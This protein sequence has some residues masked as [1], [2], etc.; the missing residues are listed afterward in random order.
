MRGVPSL[1]IVD[2]SGSLR[3][4]A[5][6]AAAASLSSEASDGGTGLDKFLRPPRGGESGGRRGRERDAFLRRLGA[7]S[8]SYPRGQT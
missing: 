3:S 4:G 2:L 5:V 1:L 6:A 8:Y 7:V